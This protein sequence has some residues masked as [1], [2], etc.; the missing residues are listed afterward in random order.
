VPYHKKLV[1]ST[2]AF[3]RGLASMAGMSRRTFHFSEGSSNKFWSIEVTGSKTLVHFGKIGTSGQAQEKD[4][5]SD[6]AAQSAGA[7]LVAEK[8][9]KGYTEQATAGNAVVPTPIVKSNETKEPKESGRPAPTAKSVATAAPT[10]PPEQSVQSDRSVGSDRSDAVAAGTPLT[11]NLERSIDL[12]EQDWWWAT[13]RPRRVLPLPEVRPFDRDACLKKL[14]TIA[15]SNWAYGWRWDFLKLPHVISQEEAAFW[16]HAASVDANKAN[17]IMATWQWDKHAPSSK[18]ARIPCEVK[19]PL[20]ISVYGLHG[21]FDTRDLQSTIRYGTALE[22]IEA[23]HST[24]LPYLTEPDRITLRNRLMQGMIPM[25]P[26]HHYDSY[27]LAA[28]IAAKLGESNFV[29]TLLQLVPTGHYLKIPDH[30]QCPQIL[31]FA[32]SSEKKVMDEM[33]RIGAPLKNPTHVKA[34]LACTEYSD[35]DMISTGIV[36]I[37]NRDEATKLM[38]HF[39]KV[40]A[41][42][43]VAPMFRLIL[44]SKVPGM[45][46]Q[47]LNENP[48]HAVVGAANLACGKG[49]LAEAATEFLLEVMAKGQR[50]LLLAAV[51]HVSAEAAEFLQSDILSAASQQVPLHDADSLPAWIKE[52]LPDLGKKLQKLPANQPI[53]VMPIIVIEGRGLPP[54]QVNSLCTLLAKADLAAPP[55]VFAELKKHAAQ[56]SHD[57]F[58]WKLFSS[59]LSD[60]A[61]SKEKWAVLALGYLGGDAIALKLAPMVRKW[62]GESQHQRAVSGLQVLRLIGTDTALMQLN[63]IAQKVPFKGLKERARELMD[64]IAKDRGL[65]KAQLEDRIVPDCGLDAQGKRS[66]DFGPRQFELLLSSDLKPMIRDS[67]GKKRPDLPAPNSS[68]DSTMAEEAVAEWKLLKKNLR[69]ILKIQTE[70]LEQAMVTGR[71][72]SAEEFDMLLVRHPLMTHFSRWV[73]WACYDASGNVTHT[74]RVNDDQTL[75]DASDDTFTLPAEA[76]IGLAHALQLDDATR[77]TWGQVLGDYE[78]IQPF[79]QLGRPVFDLLP[80]EKSAVVITRGVGKTVAAASM[81]GV[82]EKNGWQR[83]QPADAG[84]YSAHSKQFPAADITAFAHYDPGMWVGGS[85]AE[86]DDQQVTEVYFVPGMIAPDWWSAHKNQIPL[87]K[88]DPIVLSEVLRD[89]E[90]IISKAK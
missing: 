31:V 51:P 10:L 88:V 57:A 77:N 78:I 81:Y 39:M 7:K 83:D 86:M 49:K 16:L 17:E 59:W 56:A 27:P 64:E 29:E 74:F 36:G 46:R 82:F 67:A 1:S 13:W 11:L 23:I 87:A 35:L 84:G 47:W 40:H 89:L 66:F 12:E 52:G 50:D 9:K 80:E 68:D 38:R 44:E 4:W 24:V 41:V 25:P 54:A 34:W 14:K 63:G 15:I 71:R 19:Y 73:I 6:A 3:K 43:A 26:P 32:L 20:E 75:A 58:A 85:M 61:P 76:Q 53:E 2:L 65:T 33:R 69:E 79:P 70:R 21:W 45:A 30:Y 42:E 90:T 8:T 55:A 48:H 62:P 18:T 37:E 60:G 5:G 22:L 28:L 72:W